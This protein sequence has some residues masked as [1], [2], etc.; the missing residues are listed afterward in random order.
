M[1][2][3]DKLAHARPAFSF[4]F[5]PPKTSA[6]WNTLHET[7]ARLRGFEPAYVSVTY[8]AGGSNRSRT[9]ETVSSIKRDYGLEAMAHVTCVGH[10]RAELREVFEQLQEGGIENVIAL[11]GDPPKGLER[12]EPAPDGLA[13]GSELAAFIREE[14]FSFCIA[15][16]AYPEMHPES[17]DR[18]ADLA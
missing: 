15:G 1:R 5:F 14:G 13:H 17:P 16:A 6:G 2:I 7:I 11:R 4:E 8:G 12:F 3:I 10:S 18:A 9:I